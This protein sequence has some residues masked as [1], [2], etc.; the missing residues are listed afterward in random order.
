MGDIAL[1]ENAAVKKWVLG[2]LKDGDEPEILRVALKNRG[3][4]A[5]IVDEIA[6][7]SSNA[8]NVSET[9]KTKASQKCGERRLSG[10]NVALKNDITDILS[11]GHYPASGNKENKEKKNAEKTEKNE[12]IETKENLLN[13]QVTAPEKQKQKQNCGFEN[14]REKRYELCAPKTAPQ[15]ENIE[16]ESLWYLIVQSVLGIF[17]KLKFPKIRIPA[18]NEIGLK[19]IIISFLILLLAAAVIYGLDLYADRMARNVLS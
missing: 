12:K 16:K 3:Y 9:A 10:F 1:S 4:D 5:S 15:E 7:A 8:L 18:P 19:Y 2:R 13:K 11:A 6:A 14:G 17:S